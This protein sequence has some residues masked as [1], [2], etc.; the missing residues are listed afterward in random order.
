MTSSHMDLLNKMKY[1]E[2][3]GTMIFSH[4]A[5]SNK[6]KYGEYSGTM[7]ISHMDLSNKWNVLIIVQF[8]S[9]Q[10]NSSTLKY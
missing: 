3:S 4:M 9:Y 8:I 7:M 10:C 2:Y 5:L 1:N 6:M